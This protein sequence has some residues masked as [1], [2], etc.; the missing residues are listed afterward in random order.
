MTTAYQKI[1]LD[2]PYY[3][4]RLDVEEEYWQE[5]SCGILCLKM[6]MDFLG[7]GRDNYQE[8]S[9]KELVKMGVE[10]GGFGPSGWVHDVLVLIAR[11]FWLCAFRKEYK[12][13]PEKGIKE[14]LDFLE[15]GRPILA[16]A[17]KD[18]REKDRFH[19]V[20]LTGLETDKGDLKGFYYHEPDSY[21]REKG[22]HKFVAIDAFKE[23]WRKMAIFVE[24]C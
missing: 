18:F 15:K 3:S 19:I 7:R 24:I 21:D 9:I 10:R 16:S 1:I 11:D 5:R 20:L 12:N 14:I 8:K 17:I 13:N 6:A 22:K 23:N 2:V 4:Q